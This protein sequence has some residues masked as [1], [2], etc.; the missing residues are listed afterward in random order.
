MA[1]GILPKEMNI[2]PSWA[3]GSTRADFLV[4]TRATLSPHVG[5]RNPTTVG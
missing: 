4:R 1:H 5:G 3:P 2:Q